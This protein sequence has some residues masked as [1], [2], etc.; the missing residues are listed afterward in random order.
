MRKVRA[1]LHTRRNHAGRLMG[2]KPRVVSQPWNVNIASELVG[3]KGNDAPKAD[4]PKGLTAS[5]GKYPQVRKSAR[6]MMAVRTQARIRRRA[7]S[8]CSGRR[9]GGTH[10]PLVIPW[11]GPSQRWGCATLVAAET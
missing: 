9:I 4:P 1:R 6:K 2:P 7:T 11:G 8:A 10:D 5:R 3:W